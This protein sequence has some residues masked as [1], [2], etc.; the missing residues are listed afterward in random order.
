MISFLCLFLS[1]SGFFALI[2]SFLIYPLSPFPL[3]PTHK[4]LILDGYKSCFTT[5]CFSDLAFFPVGML[6]SMW[7]LINSVAN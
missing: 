2:D 6:I 5:P 1:L 4:S 3:P 7:D